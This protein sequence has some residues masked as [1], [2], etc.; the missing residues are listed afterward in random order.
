V[1]TDLDVLAE[2]AARL[3][4]GGFQFDNEAAVFEELGRASAG[5]TA[6]YR[7]ITHARLDAGEQLHWPCPDTTHPGTPRLF[8]DDFPT[9]DGRARFHV[10]TPTEPAEAPDREYPLYLTTGRVLAQY[11]SGTQTRRLPELVERAPNPRVELHPITA[12]QHGVATGDIVTVRTRRGAATLQVQVTGNA[13]VD[14]LFVPFH[15]GGLGSANLLTN[16]ALDPTSRMP[17]FKV[18]AARLELRVSGLHATP[19]VAAHSHD[20]TAP[21]GVASFECRT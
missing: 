8:A 20:D 14:T 7:G 3:G 9:S 10:V 2:L 13:R 6:D 4:R 12:R 19:D 15:W 5:G 17:E 16:P 21:V 11:Q 18:C 1:R